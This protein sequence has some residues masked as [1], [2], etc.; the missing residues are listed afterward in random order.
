MQG[1]KY[2]I[3]SKEKEIRF[4]IRW[5]KEHGCYSRYV[6]NL[7]E[8]DRSFSFVK[9]FITKFSQW[10]DIILYSFNFKE[11]LRTYWQTKSAFLQDDAEAMFGLDKL[12][13]C[14]Q[15]FEAS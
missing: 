6:R 7:M 4:F 12:Y 15:N 5:L 14:Y 8:T 1:E 10:Q 3:V 2:N 9:H 13:K 11:N